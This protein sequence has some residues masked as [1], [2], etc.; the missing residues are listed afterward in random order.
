M[1]E[2][3]AGITNSVVATFLMNRALGERV[4]EAQM[5]DLFSESRAFGIQALST[6]FLAF[7]TAGQFRTSL[8]ICGSV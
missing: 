2:S 3:D 7:S 5:L 8:V 1:P 4:I 6:L